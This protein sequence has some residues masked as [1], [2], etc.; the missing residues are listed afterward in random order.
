MSL[1]ALRERLHPASGREWAEG[2]RLRI[3]DFAVR[4]DPELFSL[5]LPHAKDSGGRETFDCHV[6]PPE[7]G[8]YHAR[9]CSRV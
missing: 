8:C 6:E 4:A 7:Q 2:V 3:H 5:I 9:T 1:D